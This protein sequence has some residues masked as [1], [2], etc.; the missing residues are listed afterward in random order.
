MWAPPRVRRRPTHASTLSCTLGRSQAWLKRPWRAAQVKSSRTSS[1]MTY[2]ATRP[3]PAYGQAKDTPADRSVELRLRAVGVGWASY[4]HVGRG[5]V[6]EVTLRTMAD[7]DWAEDRKST[8]IDLR[9]STKARDI[10]YLGRYLV[11]R[12]GGA[13]ARRDRPNDG[14]GLGGRAQCLRAR[15]VDDQGSTAV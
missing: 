4:W 11:P 15:P 6:A 13:R 2:A 5:H 8:I 9:Q 7:A 14:A 10:G 12:L 1:V 3:S